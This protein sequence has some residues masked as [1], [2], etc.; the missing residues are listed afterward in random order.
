MPVCGAYAIPHRGYCSSF[1]I[2]YPYFRQNAKIYAPLARR[3]LAL[4]W[5]Y[6]TLRRYPFPFA[7]VLA[8]N[9]AVEE[10]LP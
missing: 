9:K 5:L 2:N 1:L 4:G 7:L 10:K 8:R 3:A 6:G